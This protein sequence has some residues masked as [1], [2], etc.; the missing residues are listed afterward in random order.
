[1]AKAPFSD[2]LLYLRKVCGSQA[3][4]DL[5]D[6]QLLERF[7]VYRD[8]V[9]FSVLVHRHGPMV[10]SACRRVLGNS[11]GAEDAF[12]ATF[13]ILVRRLASI[14]CKGSLGGWL[15]LV[16]QR[17]ATKARD[18]E[19]IRHR[20]ERRLDPMQA[21]EPLDDLTWQEL[22]GVLDE[23]IARLA[24]KYRTPIVLCYL[25]GKSYDQAARE[26]GW[27][28]SSLTRRLSRARELL[29]Q[30]LVRRGMTLSAGVLA[31]ALCEKVAGAPVGAMLTINTV[32]AA[33]SMGA[34]KAVAGGCISAGAVA[35]A[36]ETM[37][38]MLAIKGKLTL[39]VLVVALGVGGAGV[40]SYAGLGDKKQ[41]SATKQ[42]QTPLANFDKR[43]PQKK[44]TLVATDLYGDPLPEGAVARLGTERFRHAIAV[45]AIA[46][47]PNGKTL[48]T[49]GATGLGLC[50]WD[51]ATGRPLHKVTAGF[52]CFALAFSPDGKLICTG[53]GYVIDVATGQEV[54]RLAE[55]GAVAFA[56]DGKT[57]AV[58]RKDGTVVRVVLTDVASA[59]ELRR[60]EVET[61]GGPNPSYYFPNWAL[62][63]FSPDGKVI[64][65]S[66]GDG[67]I[68]VWDMVT[69]NELRR[70]VGKGKAN[71]SIA[72]SPSGKV[73]AAAG[74][75]GAIRLWEPTT[76][77]LLDELKVDEGVPSS[78]VF[79]PDGK[80]LASAGDTGTIRLWDAGTGKENRRWMT[81]MGRIQIAF[82]PD[83][84]VLAAGGGLEIDIRRWDTATG[85]EVDPSAGHK[86]PVLSLQFGPDG[87]TL[88]SCGRDLKVWEWDIA[89]SQQ[90]RPLFDKPLAPPPSMWHWGATDLSPDG[91]TLAFSRGKWNAAPITDDKQDRAI[92]VWDRAPG[93]ESFVL[94]GHEEDVASVRLS[95][96]G[97]FLA[98]GGKDG[99][100]LWDLPSGKELHHLKD[101][102]ERPAFAFSPEAKLLAFT[103][104]NQKIHLWQFATREE[105][106][107]WDGNAT[108]LI[109]SPEGK[110]LAS[111]SGSVWSI[112]TGKELAKIAWP[113]FNGNQPDSLAVSPSGRLLAASGRI[114]RI[115]GDG[116]FSSK[117]Q[118]SEL[119]SGQEIQLIERPQ[120]ATQP[121]AF[122]PD[123][124]ILASGDGNSSIL[125]WDLTGG[126]QAGELKPVSLTRTQLDALWSDLAT[127][128]RKADSAIWMMVRAA[129]QSVPLLAERLRSAA[130][131][132]ADRVVK[133]VADLDDKNFAARQQAFK[134]LDDL[135]EAA[136]AP[137][138]NA[139]EGN[140]TL[141]VRQRIEQLLE[142]RN[143]DTIRK[144]R[145]TEA[146]EHIATP[147]A[148]KVL[149]DLATGALIPRVAEA[150]NSALKR[151]GK[152]PS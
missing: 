143:K 7:Q 71:Y 132:A 107:R 114:R 33:V 80:L 64:A 27:P 50:L 109:F 15:Q 2:L 53:Q 126:T 58:A 97:K 44:D 70:F 92:L 23:E 65:L 56:A 121:L 55:H 73:L 129:K 99:I 113:G 8:E 83:G 127:D 18:K 39:L 130:P 93:K 120:W 43:G 60:F 48:A 5:T 111:T 149:Q 38:G 75:D 151:L 17:V 96:D 112:E 77:R 146:L 46:Y 98:S 81:T 90:R 85:R 116:S 104:P 36:E 76:G 68:Q 138:R 3:A 54:G 29:R 125:L 106:R 19:T 37:G 108:A 52:Q 133:L 134:A 78:V 84:K 69:G 10:L 41:P 51:A 47:S 87:N 122:S 124:R 102:E 40:A 6:A 24:E 144:L 89:T 31:T 136:E 100:R 148:K 34:G 72:F 141:E 79:S 74:E 57:V 20:R 145:V 103:G 139:L 1:M 59:L 67:T 131:A 25:E 12:Q 62:P 61:S 28:K 21:R 82:S 42:V 9:S 4:R 135:G 91:K 66:S 49:G 123:G 152:R 26:L 22:R 35:L 16:A 117:I 128:A 140:A 45:F 142:R 32:K 110:V 118:L 86:G 105:L 101:V 137:L 11:H 119:F 13:M 95:P 147:E 115:P 150:A 14:S 30:R 63:V 88:F 94:T